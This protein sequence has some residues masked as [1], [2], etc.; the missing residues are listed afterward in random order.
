MYC[1]IYSCNSRG[2]IYLCSKHWVNYWISFR[3]INYVSLHQFV[4]MQ[5]LCY[6]RNVACFLLPFN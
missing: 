4:W 5:N 6:V 3:E 1:F 2:F